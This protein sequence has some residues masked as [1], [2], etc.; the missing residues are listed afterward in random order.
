MMA[1]K[2]GSERAHAH[3]PASPH[4]ADGQ[5]LSYEQLWSE[6]TPYYRDRLWA[7]RWTFLTQSEHPVLGLPCYHLHPCHTATMMAPIMSAGAC[8]YVLS[9]LSLVGPAVGLKM[10]AAVYFAEDTEPPAGS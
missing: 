8:N 9:W 5:P 7:G 3:Q 10:A 1:E 6:L 2:L 4:P